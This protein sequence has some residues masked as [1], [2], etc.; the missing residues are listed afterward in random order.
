MTKSLGDEFL[1]SYTSQSAHVP[2]VCLIT[3]VC[4]PKAREC[5]SLVCFLLSP[6]AMK[7]Q[8]N[9]F[10]RPSYT[11]PVNCLFYIVQSIMEAEAG[12]LRVQGLPGLYSEPLSPKPTP[13]EAVVHGIL[14]I[15]FSSRPE[16]AVLHLPLL[17]MLSAH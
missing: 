1:G 8:Q 15:S 16:A 10:P 13:K 14:S 12:G 7:G 9:L 4:L 17:V 11:L 6:L 3:P 2:L 5:V